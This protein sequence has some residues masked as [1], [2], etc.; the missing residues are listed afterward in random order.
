MK[1]EQVFVKSKSLKHFRERSLGAQTD[2]FYQW[3]DAQGFSKVTIRDHISQISHF[4]RYL[5]QCGINSHKD[6]TADH[7]VEFFSVYLPQSKSCRIGSFLQKAMARSVNR[8]MEYLQDCGFIDE[9]NKPA[10]CYQSLLDDYLEWLKTYHNSSP[11]TLRTRHQYLVQ[12][13]EWLGTDATIERLSLLTAERTQSYFLNYSKHHGQAARRSMQSTL[14]TFFRFCIA[15]GYIMSDLSQSVP[16]LRAYKLSRLPGGIE[17]EEAQRLLSS[18]DRSTN[19]G[20]RD[21]AIIQMLYTYGVRGGQVCALRF[22]NI[23]WEQSQIRFKALKH[24]KESLLPLTDNVGES[25]LDYLQNARPK[26]SYPEI[27]LTVRAPYRPLRNSDAISTIIAYRM[28]TAG[29]KSPNYGARAFRHCFASQMLKKGY[30]LKFIADMIGHRDIRTTFIYTK[31]DF[32]TLSQV[33]LDW[34]EEEQ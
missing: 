21:Y 7:V 32:Q 24:G 20:R 14:R 4:N 28:H 25:L 22:D 29:I 6:L 23:N 15:Q 33:A 27:F 10:T 11:K 8:F 5:E 1:L 12:F 17:E 34:P 31:V 16:T 3:L 26:F 19:S 18:I 13:L 30:S 9:W 2:G